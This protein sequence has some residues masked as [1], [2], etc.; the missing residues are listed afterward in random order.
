MKR[1]VLILCIVLSILSASFTTAFA[2]AMAFDMKEAGYYVYVSTPDGG[3]NMRYGPGT[4]YDRVTTERIPDGTKLYIEYVSG[5]WGYTVY[6]GEDGWI[7]LKQT[8]TK[9]PDASSFK[10]EKAGY[11]VYVA[12]PDGGL[13]MRSGPSTNYG[14]VMSERIPDEAELYI[15]YVSGNW[16]YTEYNGNKG[17]V[18]LKQTTTEEP[19]IELEAQPDDW[20]EKGFLPDEAEENSPETQVE[21][22]VKIEEVTAAEQEEE[23]NAEQDAALAQNSMMGQILIIIVLVLVVIILALILIIVI[24]LK[25]KK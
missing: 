7:A 17:W 10:K 16:G 14:K 23:R 1:T 12:T 24:S 11:Y 13:N 3:L 22:D 21:D 5:N 25:S 18:A 2:D 15:E 9:L 4:D 20:S 6:N 19:E 8:S